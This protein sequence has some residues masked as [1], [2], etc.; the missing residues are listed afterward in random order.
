[1]GFGT[2]L[3]ELFNKLLRAFK[4]FIAEVFD[5]TKKIIIAEFKEFAVSVVL[6]LAGTDLT[7]EEKRAA[8]FEKIKEE[9]KARGQ[10]ISDSLVGL[11]IEMAVQYIKK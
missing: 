1:M 5:D 7:N 4:E 9:A 3:K 8:A 6:E 11:L 10:E 2:W